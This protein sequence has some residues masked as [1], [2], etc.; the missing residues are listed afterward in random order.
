MTDPSH[1]QVLLENSNEIL[2]GVHN[3]DLCRD[4]ICTIHNMTDH[5]M[6]SFPQHW[7][8]DRGI[9]ER[10]CPHGVGHPDPDD[11]HVRFRYGEGVHGCDG[12]CGRGRIRSTT[13]THRKEGIIM[14]E[15]KFQVDFSKTYDGRYTLEA[16][17]EDQARE[18]ALEDLAGSYAGEF[19]DSDHLEV[20]VKEIPVINA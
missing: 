11:F 15:K 12:C 7:R 1:N 14:P 17:D 6:R 16:N 19:A 10:I 5:S 20:S 18:Y 4:D 9:M 13:R 2:Y 8:G 3:K